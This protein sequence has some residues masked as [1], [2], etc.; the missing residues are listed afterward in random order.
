MFCFQIW[1]LLRHNIQWGRLY[2]GSFGVMQIE[3]QN[4]RTPL[5][6]ETVGKGHFRGIV[7]YDRW[8]LNPILDPVIDSG[9]EMGLPK[10]YQIVN[11]PMAY[12]PNQAANVPASDSVVHPLAGRNE[13]EAMRGR[14]P[15]MPRR[16]ASQQL[17]Q[18]RFLRDIGSTSPQQRRPVR[19]WL[20]PQF[21][22]SSRGRSGHWH[23]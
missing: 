7:V 10:F 15:L 17:P 16:R 9:P 18:W 1:M 21:A 22:T 13:P 20:W 2:G 12:S 4:L 8:Q 5:R 11:N 19:R 14:S 23:R 3:G 6:L